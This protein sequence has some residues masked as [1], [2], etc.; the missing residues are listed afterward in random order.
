M[1]VATTVIEVGVDVPN[2]TIMIVQE[3]DRFGL[4]Q[5]HQLRGR[6]G[7]G[8]EQSYCLLVSRP[9][10][11]LTESAARA[12]RGAGRH[13]RRLRARRARPRAA[14]RGRSC[15]ARASP[16][17]PTSAS[18]GSRSDRDAARAGARR[19]A[20][21]TD[22]RRWPP[23]VDALLGEAAA[24]RRVAE[25]AAHRPVAVRRNRTTRTAGAPNAVGAV[26][27]ATLQDM[28]SIAAQAVAAA[29]TGV[30]VLDS[31][32][33]PLRA[34]ADASAFSAPSRASLASDRRGSLVDVGRS[35]R[36]AVAAASTR[37]TRPDGR[38]RAVRCA[39]RAA[40]EVG[41][42]VRGR[43]RVGRA[44]GRRQ[45]SCSRELALARARPGRSCGFRAEIAHGN[46]PGVRA[47]ARR[48]SA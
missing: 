34:L 25:A 39:T 33:G 7:R 5:L 26:S 40:F 32:R 21:A 29:A 22:R 20:R 19:R 42:R 18:R 13:D 12:A 27:A 24:P 9:K 11:E 8:A 28:D 2:A 30:H 35:G 15:S 37:Q 17:S 31:L 41:D 48:S 16:G 23:E 10:E 14:R 4:A 43:R 1:L 45:A 38:D 36:E 47:R 44:G 3:A 46:A 6:V